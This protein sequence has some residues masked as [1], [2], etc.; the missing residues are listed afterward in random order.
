M[1]SISLEVMPGC[2]L[3]KSFYPSERF[4]M[5]FQLNSYRDEHLGY[6]VFEMGPFDIPLYDTMRMITCPSIW[7]LL[8]SQA[9][10]T[11]KKPARL[12]KD[13]NMASRS[14]KS[15]AEAAKQDKIKKP[16]LV[17]RNIMECLTRFIDEPTDITRFAAELGV[18][19]ATLV[20]KTR[21]LTGS[22]VQKLHE[23][24]KMEKAMV[25]LE[26]HE[27]SVADIAEK[28]G[29]GNQFYFSSVF[30]RYTGMPPLK[31]MKIRNP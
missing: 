5:M 1:N 2:I 14:G 23:K 16:R 6:I 8:K 4:S 9:V 19:V 29:Y 25:L 27:Y 31:W 15:S 12:M 21:S 11:D 3:P 13:S 24:I 10:N 30:K 20:R 22:S 26:N 7:R 18:S 17:S 28:L